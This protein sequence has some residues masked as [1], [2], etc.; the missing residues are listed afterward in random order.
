MRNETSDVYFSQT[1]DKDESNSLITYAKGVKH[2]A[3]AKSHRM[4]FFLTAKGM[5]E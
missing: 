2:G 4:S 1:M 5:E 3:K